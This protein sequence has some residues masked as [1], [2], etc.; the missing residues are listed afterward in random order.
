[1]LSELRLPCVTLASI[2]PIRRLPPQ[3]IFILIR[4]IKHMAKITNQIVLTAIELLEQHPEGVKLSELHDKIM[5]TDSSFNSNIIKFYINNLNKV[6]ADKVYEPTKGL[7]RLIKFKPVYYKTTSDIINRPIEPTLET[8]QENPRPRWGYIDT[9]RIAFF[10]LLI[11]TPTIVN[12]LVPN[13]H[14]WKRNASYQQL[15]LE[16]ILLFVCI[17]LIFVIIILLY[18]W[19]APK[20]SDRSFLSG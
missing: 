12:S 16:G 6:Y 17:S 2:L 3:A 19:I 15:L 20:Y 9:I 1:M 13:Y 5:D 4:G 7:F 18:D 14:P 11:L 8:P 10:V